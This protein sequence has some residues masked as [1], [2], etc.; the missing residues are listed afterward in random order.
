[1]TSFVRGRYPHLGNISHV[2]D[3]PVL[4]SFFHES[5][6]TCGSYFYCRSPSHLHGTFFEKNRIE[7]DFDVR[8]PVARIFY[9]NG[10]QVVRHFLKNGYR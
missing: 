5:E 7:A 9:N 1:M 10:Y 2:I 8:A 6:A 3:A 4:A